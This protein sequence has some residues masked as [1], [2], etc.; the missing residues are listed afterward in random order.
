MCGPESAWVYLDDE[1]VAGTAYLLS[2]C[3]STPPLY[4]NS[5]FFI[6]SDYLQGAI[7]NLPVALVCLDITLITLLV[8]LPTHSACVLSTPFL[9]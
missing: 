8:E 1:S 5:H 6:F 7:L 2:M 3:L 4:L 9:I